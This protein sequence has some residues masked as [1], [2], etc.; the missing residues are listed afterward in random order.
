MDYILIAVETSPKGYEGIDLFDEGSVGIGF[1]VKCQPVADGIRSFHRRG[2]E[3]I[4][5]VVFIL[6]HPRREYDDI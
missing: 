3:G 1:V 5:G 6:S 4:G 2:Q